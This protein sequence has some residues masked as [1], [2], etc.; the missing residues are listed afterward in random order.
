M[1][2]HVSFPHSDGV[3]NPSGIRFG[4]GEIYTVMEQFSS[5]VDDSL[6]VGQRRPQ[7]TDERVLLFLK[8]RPGHKISTELVV[9]IRAAIRN[10]LSARHVPAYIFEVNDI[11]VS[12]FFLFPL[13][14]SRYRSIP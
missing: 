10:S 14:G 2:Y 9:N 1:L 7:D 13:G 12:S 6:C 5:K 8:M 4:S 11:P 3:L